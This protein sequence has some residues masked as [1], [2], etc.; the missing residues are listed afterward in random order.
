VSESGDELLKDVHAE[1][2]FV[3]HVCR[4][5]FGDERVPEI[6]WLDPTSNEELR[7][8]TPNRAV[9]VILLLADIA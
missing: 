4:E 1:P 3:D 8:V 2:A 5:V 9:T 7:E 6:R